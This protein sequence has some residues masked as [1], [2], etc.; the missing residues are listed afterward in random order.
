VLATAG[1][2]TRVR[3]FPILLAVAAAL[4]QATAAASIARGPFLQQTG[5]SST[6]VVVRTDAPASVA[7][8]ADLP[9]GGAA[10]ATSEGTSHLLRLEGLPAAT[11]V[12]YRVTVDG[13]EKATGT[14]RT[15]G[16]QGTAAS[17]HAVMAVIGDMGTGG[18]VESA[19]VAAMKARGVDAVLTVGDNAYASGSD[20]EWD[21]KFFVPFA[22]LLPETTLWPAPGDHEYLTPYAQAY[23]DAF[24]LPAG[25]QGERYYSFDWG[26]L[27]VVSIDTNCIKPIDPA[28]MGCDAATMLSWL[29]AD[30]GATRASWRIA[31]MHRPAV[32][33]GHYGVYP[34][35]AAALAPL[36]EEAKVDL[37]FEGHN[38]L[39]ERTWPTR[40]GQPTAHDYDH[41]TAPVYVTS[42]GGGDWLYDLTIPA[43]A[44]TAFRAKDYQHVVFTLDVGRLRVE[45]VRPDRTV[46]DSFEIVKDVTAYPGTEPGPG[47]APGGGTPGGALAGNG[48]TSAGGGAGLL[49]LGLLAAL[50]VRRR[51]RRA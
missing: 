3:S 32:A 24:E 4:P 44:Y 35:I 38:H 27:H 2:E 21:P 11:T 8:T 30:L 39:Y 9:G 41:P 50:A 34:E 43:A 16:A 20:A 1:E 12:P 36:F 51:R 49:S 7:A 22:P 15:P 40:Q 17:Q 47:G 18:P 31:I 13:V 45:S 25:P 5:P 10:T 46:L 19:N 26:D 6:L 33:T 42:G 37:V 23:L 48:C 29:R 28:T 14:V